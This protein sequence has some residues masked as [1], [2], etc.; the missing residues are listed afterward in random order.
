MEKREIYR[1]ISDGFALPG[2]FCLFW[3]GLRFLAA[4]GAF[5]GLGYLLHRKKGY[6]R[7]ENAFSGKKWLLFGAV[8]L[9][10][11]ALFAALFQR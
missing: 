11:S 5:R 3:G 1:M 4:K 9:G 10:I 8:S 2:F 7:E 6:R